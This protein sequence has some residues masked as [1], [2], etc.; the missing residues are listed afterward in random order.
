MCCVVSAGPWARPSD[1]QTPLGPSTLLNPA[2]AESFY[3]GLDVFMHGKTKLIQRGRLFLCVYVTWQYVYCY[4]WELDK[5]V[6]Y[7]R[8]FHGKTTHNL[9]FFFIR[10]NLEPRPLNSRFS[11]AVVHVTEVH[12][13][14]ELDAKSEEP[15]RYF[16]PALTESNALC[17]IL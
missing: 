6:I 10:K 8:V 16:Q 15:T 11:V 14:S 12:A 3:L 13:V 7:Y 5:N 17:I 9:T 4:Y 2:S 1:K